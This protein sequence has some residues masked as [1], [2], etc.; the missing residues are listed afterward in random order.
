MSTTEEDER[1]IDEH[2]TS[3]QGIGTWRDDLRAALARGRE[4]GRRDVDLPW[5]QAC[6]DAHA[7][8]TA[9]GVHSRRP[10]NGSA[11]LAERIAWLIADRDRLAKRCEDLVREMD[12]VRLTAAG[13]RKRAAKELTHGNDRL[14]ALEQRVGA[15]VEVLMTQ[16]WSSEDFED[17]LAALR[18]PGVGAPDLDARDLRNLRDSY[19]G[20]AQVL[21]DAEIEP[22]H[23]QPDSV[24]LLVAALATSRREEERLV[25]LLAKQHEAAVRAAADASTT[26]L[27]LSEAQRFWDIATQDLAHT[28]Q[29]RDEAVAVLRDWIEYRDA[30]GFSD[31]SATRPH[32]DLL[33]RARAIVAGKATPDPRDAEIADLR[34]Q[35]TEAQGE[36]AGMA[37]K[38]GDLG[39]A[40][41]A[42]ASDRDALRAQLDEAGK[43][44]ERVLRWADDGD[45]S[46]YLGLLA[47]LRRYLGGGT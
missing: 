17:R 14:A 9:A 2:Y 3:R 21:A 28:A 15:L 26:R 29:Q 20:I 6:Q 16:D 46:S 23:S 13:E 18:A 5:F 36:I 44:I 8:L 34:A 11:T 42:L 27:E 32:R 1:W 45:H 22:G 37:R 10:D 40:H 24:R 33:T 7:D 31:S 39:E 43:M 35:L 4:Q 41:A 25:E 47:D 38:L 12:A 30:H 19:K